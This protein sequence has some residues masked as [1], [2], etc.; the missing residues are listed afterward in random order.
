V[1]LRVARIARAPDG[2]VAL[3]GEGEVVEW[4]VEMVR[5]PARDML[6][7]KLERGEVDNAL[8]GE[9]ARRL[10]GFHAAAR[11]GPGVDEH[12]SLEA[13][14]R[15]VRESLAELEADVE[16]GA[17]VASRR[18]ADHLSKAAEGFLDRS[19]ALFARRVAEGRARDGHGDLHAGN[20]CVTAA[21]IVAYDCIEFSDRFR[22]SDV[23]CD[24]AFLAMDL[25]ARGFRGFSGVLVHAYGELAGDAE[26]SRV[27]DF[28]KAY[29]AL[30]RGK[31][32]A[33]SA[34]QAASTGPRAESRAASMRYLQLAASYALPPLLVL[35][36]GLPAS[37]KSWIAEHVARPFEAVSIGS[38]VRRKRLA[39]VRLDEHRGEGYGAGLYAPEL[40]ERAYA[41]LLESARDALRR[42]RTVVVDA[43][44]PDA[45]RRA[46]FRELA[47]SLGVALVVVHVRADE[48][49]I[50]RRMQARARDPGQPSDATWEVYLRAKPAFEPPAELARD[51]L[52]EHVSGGSSGEEAAAEVIERALEQAARGAAASPKFPA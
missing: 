13:V 20:V 44:F 23:A 45:R 33:L 36:C 29:R 40:K 10:V 50:R 34:R 48:E 18:L 27:I 28:Y 31:L 9:L 12:A 16:S 41:S 47:R 17:R 38:D 4:A 22:C 52:V 21:G 1:Y 19:R 11:T 51:E 43:T 39:Q 35:T 30:V 5:L 25:D 3:D 32:A 46:P 15:N 6:D 7:A 14:A 26:L 2:R 49:E 42:G 8:I 37:G 24:L